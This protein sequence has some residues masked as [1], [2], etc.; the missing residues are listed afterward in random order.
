MR[1]PATTQFVKLVEPDG[2]NLVSVLHTL[3]TSDRA[4]KQHIDEGMRAGFGDQFE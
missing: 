4:F 3:Y 1:S 2:S